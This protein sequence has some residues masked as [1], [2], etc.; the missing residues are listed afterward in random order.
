MTIENPIPSRQR[1][2]WT[3][4]KTPRTLGPWFGHSD[5]GQSS[6]GERKY[7]PASKA[8][9]GATAILIGKAAYA[10]F[11]FATDSPL[12]ES[13]FE[14]LVPRCALIANNGRGRAA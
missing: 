10:Q 9:G 5:G 8:P 3:C 1:D 7:P 6:R 2:P 13:G 14:L 12:E 4:A 11:E